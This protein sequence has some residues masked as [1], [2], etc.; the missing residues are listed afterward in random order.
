[1]SL[2][3]VFLLGPVL[4]LA[5]APTL[6]LAPYRQQLVTTLSQSLQRKLS[7]EGPLSV[8]LGF[9]PLLR[10]TGLRLDNPDWCQARHFIQVERAELSINLLSLLIGDVEIERLVVHKAVIALEQQADGRNNWSFAQGEQEGGRQD[11]ILHYLQLDDVDIGLRVPTQSRQ[12]HITQARL[13]EDEQAHYGMELSGTLDGQQLMIQ[14]KS[15]RWPL[16]FED[17]PMQLVLSARLGERPFSAELMLQRLAP[18]L[19]AELHIEAESVDL[20]ALLRY[21][22]KGETTKQAPTKAEPFEFAM[23]DAYLQRVGHVELGLNINE[24]R[25]QGYAVRDLIWQG[26]LVRATP[27]PSSA[28]V[29]QTNIGITGMD[30][31]EKGKEKI[32]A[33]KVTLSLQSQGLTA[34]QLL[35]SSHVRLQA[36]N[37]KGRLPQAY[38][39]HSLAL[40]TGRLGAAKLEGRLEYN[41]TPLRLTLQTEKRFF[42]KLL[43]REGDEPLNLR[44]ETAAAGSSKPHACSVRWVWSWRA[45]ALLNCRPC[46][47]WNCHRYRSTACRVKLSGCHMVLESRD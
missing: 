30:S 34:E 17:E 36:E 26:R 29:L 46:L 3:A 28:L 38:T 5:F 9:K 31:G 27:L 39:V 43:R 16:L 21:L 7:L 18:Q 40:S 37:V 42:E 44:L 6:D 33:G 10:A 12:L 14:L 19:H 11:F 41:K 35:V 25:Y 1:M 23:F 13:Q 45:N 15:D 4:F 47:V 22:P 32:T 24:F 8:K 2:L 20:D